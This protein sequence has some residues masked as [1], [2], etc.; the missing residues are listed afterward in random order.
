MVEGD[1]TPYSAYGRYYIRIDDGDIPMSNHQLQKFFEDKEDNYSSWE[2]KPTYFFSMISMKNSWLKSSE[3][4]TK[5]DGLIM[6]MMM[7]KKL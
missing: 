5:R 3:I 1:D 6:F 4:P 2:E 7:W